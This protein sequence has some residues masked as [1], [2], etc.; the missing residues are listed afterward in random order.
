MHEMIGFKKKFRR[1]TLKKYEEIPIAVTVNEIR[2]GSNLRSSHGT[3]LY[4]NRNGSPVTEARLLAVIYEQL[5]FFCPKD[6]NLAGIPA[7]P[8]LPLALLRDGCLSVI[9][10]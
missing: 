1:Q 3:S 7:I 4:E 5:E 6:V 9:N 10:T 8:M 2:H